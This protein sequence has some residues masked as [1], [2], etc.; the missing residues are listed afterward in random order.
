MLI[1]AIYKLFVLF[2]LNLFQNNNTM[3]LRRFNH[4]LNMTTLGQY[5]RLSNYGKE[6][7]NFSNFITSVYIC[8][9]L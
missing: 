5:S 4:R 2:E 9:H 6:T 7:F 1:T 3:V 8:Q